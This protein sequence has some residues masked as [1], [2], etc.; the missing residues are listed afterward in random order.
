MTERLEAVWERWDCRGMERLSVTAGP[1]GVFADSDLLT[2]TTSTRTSAS[3]ATGGG[4]P[5]TS[6]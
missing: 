6:R 3:A 1:E 5:A 2:P 4:G